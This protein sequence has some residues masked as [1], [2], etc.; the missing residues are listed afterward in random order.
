M[1]SMNEE[2]LFSSFEDLEASS[3]SKSSS[4]TDEEDYLPP[5]KLASEMN[6]NELMAQL[7]DRGAPIKGFEDEDASTL[8][9]LLDAE[10]EEEL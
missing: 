7:K 4:V 10:Y 1:T 9:K 6:H 8:Q 2:N 5:R 3:S